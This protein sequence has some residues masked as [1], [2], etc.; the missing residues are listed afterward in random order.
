MFWRCL[1]EVVEALQYTLWFLHHE[2]LMLSL[3]LADDQNISPCFHVSV[4]AI[5]SK[6]KSAWELSSTEVFMPAALHPTRKVEVTRG[7]EYM[8]ET[9]RGA[10]I[11]HSAFI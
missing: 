10:N 7:P 1:A 9:A 5:V 11:P 2:R 4:L 8:H 6:K 3:Y